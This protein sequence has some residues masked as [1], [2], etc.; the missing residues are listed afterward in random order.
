MINPRTITLDEV[1]QELDLARKQCE[2]AS[3]IHRVAEATIDRLEK[4]RDGY[5]KSA[6]EFAEHATRLEKERDEL[7]SA[8]RH[9]GE[10]AEVSTY[11]PLITRAAELLPLC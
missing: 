11:M 10:M 2:E 8:I 3:R 6:L 4:E 5:K 7:K 9:M 1:K